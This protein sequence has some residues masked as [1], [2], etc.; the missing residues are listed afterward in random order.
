MRRAFQK[1]KQKNTSPHKII[2]RLND[3]NTTRKTHTIQAVIEREEEIKALPLLQKT[4]AKKAK[5]ES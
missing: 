4:L 3:S 1:A 2:P 5:R